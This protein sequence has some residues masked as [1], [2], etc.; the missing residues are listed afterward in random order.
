MRNKK[1]FNLGFSAWE[2]PSIGSPESG[3]TFCDYWEDSW[4]D[5]DDDYWSFPD[6]GETYK[7]KIL[8]KHII[9]KPDKNYIIEK[10]KKVKSNYNFKFYFED[11]QAGNFIISVSSE[12]EFFNRHWSP[13]KLYIEESLFEYGQKN[14]LFIRIADL[15]DPNY[16]F[17]YIAEDPRF[18]MLKINSQFDI[19][20]NDLIKIIAHCTKLEKVKSFL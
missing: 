8:V 11:I 14:K 7:S 5:D 13:E 6:D 9:T 17:V 12:E 1:A 15:D 19:N 10:L 4:Y 16:Q 3:G 18:K 20:L 2:V